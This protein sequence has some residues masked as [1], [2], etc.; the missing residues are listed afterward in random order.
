LQTILESLAFQQLHNKKR[1]ALL[2]FADVM[3]GADMRVI[4]ARGGARFSAES[5]ESNGTGYQMVGQKLECY[6]TSKP[7]VFRAIDHAHTSTA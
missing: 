4:D 7:D 2:V 6:I 1:M 3:N 5:L